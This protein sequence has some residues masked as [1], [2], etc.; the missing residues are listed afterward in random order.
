[1]PK[2]RSCGR[3]RHDD[4]GV[5]LFG[6]TMS[7]VADFGI[8]SSPFTLQVL[9]SITKEEETLSSIAC[10]FSTLSQCTKKETT[11]LII[12]IILLYH[13]RVVVVGVESSK[14]DGRI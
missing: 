6:L 9:R 5:K 11:T 13:V 1:M 3:G 10:T 8:S 2:T 7:S 14:N 12:I 4:K